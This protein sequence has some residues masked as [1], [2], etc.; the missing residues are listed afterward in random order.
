[1]TTNWW[2]KAG[3]HQLALHAL[4]LAFVTLVSLILFRSMFT[5]GFI[6]TPDFFPNFPAVSN[7][8]GLGPYLSKWNEGSLGSQSAQPLGYAILGILARAGLLGSTIQ[9]VVTVGLTVFSGFTVWYIVKDRVRNPAVTLVAPLLYL[10]GPTLFISMF[11]ASANFVFFALL[12]LL[13]LLTWRLCRLPTLRNSLCLGFAIGLVSAFNPFSILFVVPPV[14]ILYIGS[15]VSSGFPRRVLHSGAL[16]A[17]SLLVAVLVN[18]PYYIGNLG[19][20]A[21]QGVAGAADVNTPLVLFTYSW[22]TPTNILSLLGG[23]LYPRYSTFYPAWSRVLLTCQTLLALFSLVHIKPD[24]NGRL[25]LS[26]ALLVACSIA[27]IYLTKSGITIPLL[28]TVPYLFAFNYPEVFYMYLALSVAVLAAF[29]ID[30]LLR[31]VPLIGIRTSLR[32]AGGGAQLRST[33]KPSPSAVVKRVR[34]VAAAAL[35]VALIMPA[36]FYIATGD[37][38]VLEAPSAFGYPPQWTAIAPDSFKAIYTFIQEHGGDQMARAL[39]LP[40]PTPGGGKTLPGFS[41]NLFNQPKYVDAPYTGPFFAVPASS[42]Y[43]TS[44]LDYLAANRTDM[45]GIPLGIASV[46]YIFVDKQLNFSGPPRWLGES[47]I[48]SPTS[49]EQLLDQQRDLVRV[50]DDALFAAYENMDYEP[51]LQAYDKLVVVAQG[52]FGIPGSKT[53]YSWSLSSS[54]WSAPGPENRISQIIN[55][56]DG[57]TVI[58]ADNAGNMSI[59]FAANS[60]GTSLIA[61]TDRLDN[62]GFYIVSSPVPVTDGEYGLR[63]NTRYQGPANHSGG[64][65]IIGGYDGNGSLLWQIRSYDVGVE[66]NGTTYLDFTP[67]SS[68]PSTRYIRL[69]V[70]FPYRFGDNVEMSYEL[71]NLTLVYHLPRPPVDML[72]PLILERLPAGNLPQTAAVVLERNVG[73]G[74]SSEIPPYTSNPAY[75]CLGICESN[76]NRAWHQ[77]LFAYRAVDFS[78]EEFRVERALDSVSGAVVAITGAARANVT[79][80]GSPF[81]ILLIRVAGYG[82]ITPDVGTEPLNPVSISSDGFRWV[83]WSLGS[84]VNVTSLSVSTNG[85]LR[86]DALLFEPGPSVSSDTTRTE[87]AP[88]SYV[89]SH[90]SK[91]AGSL[92]R[93]VG[94][95]FLA[96]G[97]DRG[98]SLQI[99]GYDVR[100]VPG[101]GWAN[102][103]LVH[104]TSSGYNDM[105]FSLTFLPQQAHNSLILVQTAT[106]ATLIAYVLAPVAPRLSAFRRKRQI[107]EPGL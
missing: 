35:L 67:M 43:S 80:G 69:T 98:W 106:G 89:S 31:G 59:R 15:S 36:G 104:T 86:I 33:I 29:A 63:Y 12:P 77:L 97:Y 48:G 28:Q 38:R 34:A 64:Y 40:A 85:T 27:W 14:L 96:Q 26:F 105:Q 71:S 90:P 52:R 93:Q 57:Y 42:E 25:R 79:L 7:A 55:E 2:R 5:Y 9:G 74:F 91:Y 102:I 4:G 62:D 23:G 45:I 39:V 72:A 76:P 54:N 101:L 75:L 50:H 1:M 73:E 32:R 68:D 87:Y 61:S 84:P 6:I 10:S 95:L 17:V 49:F 22:S 47:M 100:P 107:P 88:V 58:A 21:S 81:Q 44:V 60:Y 3:N 94:A 66:I 24:R 51:Y 70:A 78:S 19:Y 8:E 103:F 83:Q 16:I 30:D 46:K 41:I 18:A 92:S 82:T 53:V 99:D 20:L 37:F 11:D 13:A 65:V 56:R